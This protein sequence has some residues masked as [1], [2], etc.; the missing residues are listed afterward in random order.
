MAD[1]NVH[2]TIQERQKQ[3]GS[4]KI[5]AH[6]SQGIKKAMRNSTAW[7]D[8]SDDKKEA[9]EMIAMKISRIL[10][11]RADYEDNWHDIAGYAIRIEETIK[12]EKR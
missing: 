9:L 1:N 4:F 11:D 3:Y 12:E 6:I 5:N 8:L 2:A 10:T 7:V